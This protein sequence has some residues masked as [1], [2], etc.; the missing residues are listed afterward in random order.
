MRPKFRGQ[1]GF[2]VLALCGLAFAGWLTLPPQNISLRVAGLSAPV[3]ITLDGWGIPRIKA[4]TE[5]DA[6]T[7][8]GYLHA[9]DRMFEMELMR[10]AASGRLSELAG[11][12]ALPLDRFSRTLGELQHA[13]RAYKNLPDDTKALLV[14][15]STGVNAW[16]AQRGR[17]AAPEFLVLGTPELWRPVDCLL[18]NETVAV[19][20]SE[21]FRTELSRL[22]LA[23]KIAPEKILQLWPPQTGSP[24]PDASS[25]PV[26]QGFLLKDLP[27]FPDPFT[28]PNEASNAWAVDGHHTTTGAPLLAGDPH[29]SLQFP[30]LWYLARIETPANSLVGATAPGVPFLIVGRN[31]H[32]AWSF[33][34]TGADTQDIFIETPLPG[35]MYATPDGPRA[36]EI[37]QER[38][39]VLWSPDVVL[40]VRSTRHGPVISDLLGTKTDQILSLEAAQYERD[41]AAPG[42]L[43]L[44]RATTVAEAG[45]AAALI[46]SPI[47]NLTVADHDSI[48]LF[49]TGDVP[50]RRSG[51]GAAPVEGAD[52]AHD[53]TGY[54]SGD[55]LPHFVAP[56]SGILVNANERTAP[57]DF[58]VFLGQDWFAP[59]RARRIHQL[60]DAK[61]TQTIADFEAMQR[62]DVSVFAHDI[63]PSFSAL[64]RQAGVAGQAQ[65]LLAK[66]DGT[67]ADNLPQPLIFNATVQLFVSQTIAANHVPEKY[68]GPW[69][70]FAVWLLT[71][72]GGAWCGGDCHP[73]LGR[74]LHDATADLAQ[75]YGPDPSAW[76][77]GNVHQAIFSH[78]LLGELPVI[79]HLAAREVPVPG[80]DTTLFRGGN[81][82]LGQFE[83]RHG[84]G[85]RGIYDLAD[86]DR[87]RFVVTPG[88]SGNFFSPHA[89]DMLKLWAAG[90][91]VTI[92]P[93]PDTVSARISLDP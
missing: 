48:A 12:K 10:R 73:A 30:S 19:W 5:A 74:V 80:D 58:P 32:I 92:P 45:Q 88:Q 84:A 28:L 8:L 37:R 82:I 76:R 93:S 27:R 40:T 65:A 85:Y 15:Y 11:A 69:G 50:I 21:N 7:A 56:A 34:T 68:A 20:L 35:G 90:T 86:L 83:S 31:A 71:P 67:M 53:W 64:P 61:P 55:A 2:V 87:S 26:R 42:I 70:G 17:F 62:D 33:T 57:P 59:W 24:A 54:A 79:G 72:A 18:W 9:R 63:L 51:N 41:S 4:A 81:G 16:I 75:K 89:W 36:F 14:A 60:L 91:T 47:Q 49:T 44:N 29:L 1:L 43:A 39:H 6:A 38:I 66:W 3:D 13:E 23:G 52:A 78:P 46:H 25:L 77:W 22:A